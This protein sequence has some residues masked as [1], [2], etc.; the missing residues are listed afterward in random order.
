[1]VGW[2]VQMKVDGK[3]CLTGLLTAVWKGGSQV[4]LK[5]A[6]SDK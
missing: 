5:V 1:M 4:V 2:L 3:V 6:V